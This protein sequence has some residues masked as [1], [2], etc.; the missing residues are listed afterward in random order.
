MN[1]NE[2]YVS[3]YKSISEESIELDDLTIL[4]G[5]NNSGKSNLLE[6]LQVYA[7]SITG[8]SNYE[9]QLEDFENCLN[10]TD[11][12]S[13]ITFEATYKTSI[14]ERNQI[15]DL[16]D[17]LSP[18][19]LSKLSFASSLRHKVEF[20]EN[21]QLKATAFEVTINDEFVKIRERQKSTKGYDSQFVKLKN[22][23]NRGL[24]KASKIEDLPTEAMAIRNPENSIPGSFQL[25][26][27]SLSS[28]DAID[29]FRQP[30]NRTEAR[31]ATE[32]DSQGKNL[33]RV[34]QT[35]Q[36]SNRELFNL[37][38]ERFVSIMDAVKSITT[39]YREKT[40][41]TISVTEMGN[42]EKFDLSSLSSGTKEIL[43]LIFGT[44]NAE[45]E[46]E[47]LMI[48]EPELHLHPEAEREVYEMIT[49]VA[50]E[51]TQI[52][53][54][55]HSNVFVDESNISNIIRAERNRTTEFR[56][57]SS[58]DIHEEL[59]D[60]G[61]S[62]SGLLQSEGVIFVEGKSDKMVI[63]AIAKNLGYDF[64]DLGITLIPLEGES[65]MR[66]HG[67][68]LVKTLYAFGIPYRFLVDSDGKEKYEVKKQYVDNINRGEKKTEWYTTPE[69]FLVWSKYDLESYLVSCP[70]AIA[71]ET[72]MDV[73]MICEIIKYN[74]HIEKKSEVLDKIYSRSYDQLEDGNAYQKDVDGMKIAKHINDV[75]PE[76][77]N[78]IEEFVSIVG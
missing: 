69:H 16:I 30:K 49:E 73:D 74:S 62:Q 4:I 35:L 71:E 18:E 25:I 44:I 57:I 8:P 47:L 48:E 53:V 36:G 20:G 70:Q 51:S 65:K 75:P 7:Y 52:I 31:M 1:L 24:Q 67:R 66:T 5:K 37:A 3:G 59:L 76:M 10:K 54:A 12:M 46:S 23:E 34:A 43:T 50:S 11:E 28:W 64:N 19:L 17:G 41:I 77:K 40:N 32:L 2:W 60:L 33:V 29:A 6:S 58:E 42:S 68:S 63:L 61:Y 78:K 21:W 15:Y 38:E 26:E 56:S 55:T 45:N 13:T 27:D 9:D 72:N 22:M 39:P 14:E